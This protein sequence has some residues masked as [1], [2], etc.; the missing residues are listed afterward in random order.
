VIRSK[1][2][3]E[4]QIVSRV[5]S[6]HYAAVEKP[7]SEAKNEKGAILDNLEKELSDIEK[8]LGKI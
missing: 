6:K 2:G 5:A 3:P 8:K 1:S 4:K 7:V